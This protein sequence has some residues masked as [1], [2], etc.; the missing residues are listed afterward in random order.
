MPQPFLLRPEP[1]V[2]RY[3]IVTAT[4]SALVV[5]AF[6]VAQALSY[7][8]TVDSAT[9]E[10]VGVIGEVLPA[11]GGD[12]A[13][14]D[15]VWTD[16]HGEKV[17]T[18]FEVEEP[19]RFA[20][21]DTI[22]LRYVPGQ[23]R[24]GVHAAEE[25]LVYA[26][27]EG[28]HRAEEQVLIEQV[29]PVI[30]VAVAWFAVLV[31]WLVR[32]RRNRA[33]ARVEAVPMR[34]FF[35]MREHRWQKYATALAVAPNAPIGVESFA[36]RDLP[37]RPGMYW[38]RVYWDPAIDRHRAGDVVPVHLTGGRNPRAVIEPEEGLLVWPAGYASL[39]HES[40]ASHELI[41]GGARRRRGPVTPRIWYWFLP[42]PIALCASLRA[43]ALWLAPVGVL[44]VLTAMIHAWAWFAP[45]PNE[46]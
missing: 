38:Q 16:D 46:E 7:A 42:L 5:I 19:E 44:V 30:P 34:V 26:V 24:L 29:W 8:S 41:R 2:A 9:A 21:G 10:A 23:N 40:P 36:Q 17:S 12:P 28:V 45:A 22:A 32:R 25:R 4:V 15:V 37:I 6:A 39:A 43:G 1:R 18:V 11:S 13:E 31:P 3:A 35:T 14:M 27:P 33:A 20:E